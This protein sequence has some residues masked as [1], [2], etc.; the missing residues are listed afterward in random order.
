MCLIP[1]LCVWA[2]QTDKSGVCGASALD[3]RSRLT[4]GGSHRSPRCHVYDIRSWAGSAAASG[5]PRTRM[6][7]RPAISV[8][9]SGYR[10]SETFGSCE[11]MNFRSYPD[12]MVIR[13]MIDVARRH[14]EVELEAT[15][16]P[17]AWRRRTATFRKLSGTTPR[18]LHRSDCQT[19]EATPAQRSECAELHC[20]CG[21]GSVLP[22]GPRRSVLLPAAP[23]AIPSTGHSCSSAARQRKPHEASQSTETAWTPGCERA[24]R[25]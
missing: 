2:N 22:P 1:Y 18:S 9:S 8:K 19:G 6:R 24:Q 20:I 4:R 5:A 14:A 25:T 11:R 15:T 13:R 3:P 17:L 7:I 16:A 12:I 21:G 23:G 10:D